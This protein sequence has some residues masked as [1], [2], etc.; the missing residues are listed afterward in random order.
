[1]TRNYGRYIG[2]RAQLPG[3]AALA[4]FCAAALLATADA[5][6]A[7][8]A[9]KEQSAAAQ[10]NSFAGATAGAED[11][12]YMFFNPAAL[13]RIDGNQV[14]VV[15]SYIIPVADIS[16]AAASTAT[17]PVTLL[18]AATITGSTA[19][20]AVSSLVP[21]LYAAYS[22]SPNLKLGLAINVP[23]GL[24]TDYDAGWIGRYHA[25]ETE[26]KTVNINPVVA[27]RLN[28]TL[29]IAAGFQAEYAEATLS[30]AID[31]GTFSAVLGLGGTPTAA[32]GSSELTGDDW[33]FGF[34]LGVLAELSEATRIG[35]AYRSEIDHTI[36]G[37]VDF[38][39]GGAVGVA[40]AGTGAFGPFADTGGRAD[41]SLPQSVSAGAFHQINEQ[42]AVMG[43]VAWTGWSSLD[44]IRVQ[45]DNTQ[46]DS[47][48]TT[49]WDDVWF[50]ALG[51]TWRANDKWTIRGGIAYDQSPIP[52][53]T[54]TPR[55]PGADRTWFSVGARYDPAG[56]FTIDA[57]YTY[58]MF[59]DSSVNLTAASF[60]APDENTGRGNLSFDT[61][62]DIHIVTVQ[63][64]FRF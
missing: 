39:T 30:S 50:A 5:N 44:E 56:N 8:F 61:E 4:G 29:S 24:K 47:V 18:V 62:V 21:A 38:D 33:A 59:D 63:A 34:N 26:L 1:M 22:Y 23:F 49:D 41:L 32:D 42:W 53:A 9:L 2:L 10:G 36:E 46:P 45:F 11:V 14:A 16:N 31:F 15:L 57:G 37:S 35:L 25:L 64:T 58:I 40:V 55:I 28:D 54:R 6:A 60:A 17:H 20:G 7:G 3:M 12:T 27:Y 51:A 13:A 48:I 19:D 43:E 52:D